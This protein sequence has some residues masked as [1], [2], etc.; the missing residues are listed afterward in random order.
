[1]VPGLDVEKAHGSDELRHFPHRG[2]ADALDAVHL[3]GLQGRH[4]LGNGGEKWDVLPRENVD[5]CPENVGL[6]RW[7]MWIYAVKMWVLQIE[8][9]GLCPENVDFA[10]FCMWICKLE[11]WIWPLNLIR[12]KQRCTDDRE[13]RETNGYQKTPT[14][15][16]AL[17]CSW[18]P[19]L[20]FSSHE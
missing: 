17:P 5:L 19:T 16:I 20:P 18:F 12:K 13:K 10:D 4:G 15:R 7:N 3:G 1:M 2:A 6:C 14:A 9:V 8:H 11:M